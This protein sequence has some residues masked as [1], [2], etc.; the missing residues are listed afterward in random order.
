MSFVSRK[1]SCPPTDPPP[2]R[3]SVEFRWFYGVG[4]GAVLLEATGGFPVDKVPPAA[5]SLPEFQSCYATN[6]SCREYVW[7]EKQFRYDR[8]SNQ[9]S[10]NPWNTEE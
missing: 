4:S 7:N 5:L 1:K 8:S 6:L 2:R 3:C 10:G 9:A